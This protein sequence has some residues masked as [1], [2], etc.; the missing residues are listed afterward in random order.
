MLVIITSHYQWLPLVYIALKKL[1][2]MNNQESWMQPLE[3]CQKAVSEPIL[4][5]AKSMQV[6][7]VPNSQMQKGITDAWSNMWNLLPQTNLLSLPNVEGKKSDIWNFYSIK[8]FNEMWGKNW[9]TFG[10]DPFKWYME[11]I[12]KVTEL[13]IDFWKKSN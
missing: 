4:I 6:I 1:L 11:F 9:S 8:D 7:F 10:M 5:Y 3:F 13:W 2:I 12:Q